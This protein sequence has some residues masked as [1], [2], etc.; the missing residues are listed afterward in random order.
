MVVLTSDHG[1]E[2][3]EHGSVGHGHSLY[4]ELLRVPL[5]IRLPARQHAGTRRSR[6]AGLADVLPTLCDILRTPCPTQV[7]GRSLV[8]SFAADETP[9]FPAVSVSEFPSMGETAVRMGRFKTIFRKMTPVL[10]DLKNDPT[11]TTDVSAA[12]PVTLAALRDALGVFFADEAARA[13]LSQPMRA[14]ALD[15]ASEA[16]LRALGYLG[17]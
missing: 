15:E 4:E 7:Q 3:F 16:G 8:S 11:E 17:D 14:A 13:G 12:F 2:F 6:E 9:A 5:I 10:Y 1:E